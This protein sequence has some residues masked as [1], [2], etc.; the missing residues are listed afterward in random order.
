L[1]EI[2]SS[3]SF[4]Q[5]SRFGFVGAVTALFHAGIVFALV[6]GASLHSFLAIVL[7]YPPAL[8]VHFLL[9]SRLVFPLKQPRKGT[10]CRYAGA[11]L[12]SF[13]TALAFLSFVNA[14]FPWQPQWASVGGVLVG[15][16]VSFALLRLFVFPEEKH[17]SKANHSQQVVVGDTDLFYSDFYQSLLFG[18]GTTGTL[19]KL[20]HRDVERGLG[21]QVFDRVLEL[22][23]GQGEHFSFVEHSFAEYVLLDLR[24]VEQLEAVREDPRTV[25]VVGDAQDI[26]FPDSDFDRVLHMCLLHHVDNPEKVLEE[27]RR[28]MKPG[29]LA[30]LFLPCDP[31]FGVRL[32]RALTTRRR[33]AQLGF[34]GYNL[35]IA[36][37]HRNH[38]SAL[39]SLAVH[40]FRDDRV[41]V[42]Y[43]PF[44][45]PSWNLNGSIIVC[46]SKLT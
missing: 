12:V 46:V 31:G 43:F 23:A 40:V 28:V 33:A 42:D 35:L 13:L 34:K 30:T 32:M 27:I 4:S 15:A 16:I 20:M 2:L 11:A 17:H 25:Q 29:A 36:R 22:G 9:N 39:L 26:P 18:G 8:I 19:I 24:R 44:K 41:E 38:V 7:S 21:K 1:P 5:L 45:I 10:I 6:A 3:Q 14:V 37:E